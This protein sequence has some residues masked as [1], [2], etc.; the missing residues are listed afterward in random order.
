MLLVKGI[1]N[2]IL[3]SFRTLK[4]ENNTVSDTFKIV[5]QKFLPNKHASQALKQMQKTYAGKLNLY[6]HSD[7]EDI[8]EQIQAEVLAES[9]MQ[10]DDTQI[11]SEEQY[12]KLQAL[13]QEALLA[14]NGG[15]DFY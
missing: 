8:S 1:D 11:M 5:H 15:S 4:R 7:T 3:T 2:S 10:N 13:R 9:L 6:P 12:N 14:Q